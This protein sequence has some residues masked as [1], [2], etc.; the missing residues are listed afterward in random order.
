VRSSPEINTRGEPSLLSEAGAAS[1]ALTLG[2]IA[3]TRSR[4]GRRTGRMITRV[5]R[6]LGRPRRLHRKRRTGHRLTNPGM[7]LGLASGAVGDEP[8][9]QRWYRR[10]KATKRGER[11]RGESERP[12]LSRKRGNRPSWTPWRKG[13]AALWAR[14]PGTCEGIGP[15]QRVTVR[16]SKPVDGRHHDVTSRMREIRKS[17]S[18]GARGEQSPWAT[19]PVLHGFYTGDVASTKM[20][21]GNK[22]QLLWL[23]EVPKVGLEPTPSC[24]DRILSPVLLPFRWH[25]KQVGMTPK[26][27]EWKA[28]T[29]LPFHR[30][31]VTALPSRCQS[32]CQIVAKYWPA[33]RCVANWRHEKR[34]N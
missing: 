28:F 26:T 29:S 24:E 11:D 6:E 25:W 27:M 17:G 20:S 2:P 15:H 9:T 18:V 5:P 31:I 10:A 4:R 13:D 19:R 3:R 23:T 8:G 16:A 32:C 7:I 14:R 30:H 1:G 21:C 34:T 33:G 12:I 22:P